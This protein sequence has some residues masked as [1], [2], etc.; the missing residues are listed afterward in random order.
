M[1]L[2]VCTTP[3]LVARVIAMLGE[4]A[5][6]GPFRRRDLVVRGNVLIVE[7]AELGLTEVPGI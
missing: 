1:L 5:V 7:R 3:R 2:V 4:K 6:H